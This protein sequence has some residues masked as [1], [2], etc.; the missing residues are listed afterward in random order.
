MNGQFKFQS[1]EMTMFIT[2]AHCKQKKIKAIRKV[3][4]CIVRNQKCL[5]YF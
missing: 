1:L 2:F 5:T 4:Y 3:K